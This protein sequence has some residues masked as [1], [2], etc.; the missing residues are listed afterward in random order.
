MVESVVVVDVVVLVVAVPAV[1]LSK[2]TPRAIKSVTRQL[3]QDRAFS[4]YCLAWSDLSPTFRKTVPCSEIRTFM[5][6]FTA[7]EDFVNRTIGTL[8]G[9]W[10]KLAFMSGLRSEKGGYE[11]WGLEY[12][13]G[14]KAANCAIARTHSEVF[15]KV[16]ETP[17]P[18]LF[19]EFKTEEGKPLNGGPDPDRMIPDERNGCLPDHFRYVHSALTLLAD[20]HSTRRA[21]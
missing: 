5:P 9:T 17:I 12:T 13:Y 18:T 19:G 11:H 3:L 21:A 20:T 16:L 2:S 14:P 10:E 1:K 8:K 6:L 4:W 7:Y 15:Q